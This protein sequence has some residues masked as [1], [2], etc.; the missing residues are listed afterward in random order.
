MISL[1][2]QGDPESDLAHITDAEQSADLETRVER[3]WA[4]GAREH[5][6]RLT[7]ELLT[8]R[9]LAH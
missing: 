7:P 2:A 6:V 5:F 9:R 3:P 1:A 8:G 4:T